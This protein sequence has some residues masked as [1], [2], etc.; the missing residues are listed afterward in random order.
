MVQN[1]IV[2]VIV[3]LALLGFG[4]LML[5]SLFAPKQSKISRCHDCNGCDLK[6]E[7]GLKN[8]L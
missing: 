4:Y 6:R 2:I 3:G 8:G 1:I 7:L 5:K